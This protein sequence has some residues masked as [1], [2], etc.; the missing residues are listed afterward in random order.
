MSQIEEN[1]QKLGLVLP[2]V[3][4]SGQLPSREGK[5]A[6]LGKVP[7][8]VSIEQAAEAA[9]LAAVNGLAVLKDAI[10]G[11]W[12]RLVRLVRV[13]VFVQC[14]PTFDQHSKI[15]NGASDLFAAVCG[16]IGR[17][18]RTTIGVAALPLNAA[19]EVELLAQVR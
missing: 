2:P 1:L 3:F 6:Y 15:A 11:D 18:A 19:V 17:H 9:K 8:P 10:E 12:N 13:G 7:N 5:V 16:D 4:V 14:D